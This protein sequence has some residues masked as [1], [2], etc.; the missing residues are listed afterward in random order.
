MSHRGHRTAGRNGGYILY[1]TSEPYRLRLENDYTMFVVTFPRTA[2]K[3]SANGISSILAVPIR[4][5]HGVGA[6]VSPFFSGLRQ[7]L[8]GGSLN[9]QWMRGGDGARGLQSAMRV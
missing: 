8:S 4:A 9:P 1:D 7:A 6:L 3:M 5:Q 2:L